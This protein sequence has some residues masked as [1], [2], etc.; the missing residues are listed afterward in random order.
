DFFRHYKQSILE[1][2]E[3]GSLFSAAEISP[4]LETAL[5]GMSEISGLL[6]IRD[7]ISSRKYSHIV[8]DTAPFGHTL[9]LF[10]LPDQFLRCSN[11]WNWRRDEIAC[12]PPTSAAESKRLNP[13]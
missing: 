13:S 5:P 12:W 6:A 10:S 9:R 1:I 3:R 4:L 11:F 7:A 8:V 2:V